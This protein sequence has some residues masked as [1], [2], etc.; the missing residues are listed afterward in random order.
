MSYRSDNALLPGCHQQHQYAATQFY[1]SC[2]IRTDVD[3][4]PLAD[5]FVMSDLLPRLRL[6]VELSLASKDILV[7]ETYHFCSDVKG[8]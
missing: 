6:A 5:Q 8:V 1:L 2:Y 7:F 3:S 4:T